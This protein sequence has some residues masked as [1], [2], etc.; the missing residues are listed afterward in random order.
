MSIKDSKVLSSTVFKTLGFGQG[1]ASQLPGLEGM[2]T[3][4][5]RV[6]HTGTY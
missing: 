5:K 6:I 2:P 1:V 4:F 3:P